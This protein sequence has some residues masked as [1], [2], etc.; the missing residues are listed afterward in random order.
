[1]NSSNYNPYTMKVPLQS[2]QQTAYSYQPQHSYRQQTYQH[3]VPT[4]Q[5][6]SYNQPRRPVFAPA[7]Y[8]TSYGRSLPNKSAHTPTNGSFTQA[9]RRVTRRGNFYINFLLNILYQI[10]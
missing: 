8:T 7:Y 3:L 10:Y 1:M 9:P 4:P 2:Q 5:Q 6:Y